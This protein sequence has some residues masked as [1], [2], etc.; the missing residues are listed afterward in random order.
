MVSRKKAK[1]ENPRLNFLIIVYGLI[2]VVFLAR[3]FTIQVLRHGMY[4]AQA[5]NQYWNLSVIPAKRGDIVSADDFVLAGTQTHYL[6]YIEPKK[7]EEP[8]KAAH[9][10][11]DLLTSLRLV[12]LTG[13]VEDDQDDDLEFDEAYFFQ[14]YYDRILENINSELYW[15]IIEHN[16]TPVEKE[17][18]EE[19]GI[20]GIGFEEEPVR[21]YPEGRLSSHV[22]GFVAFNEQG[23]K[24]GYF[25]I[26][27]AL[28]GDLKGKPGRVLEERDALG[29]PILIGSYK[30]AEPIKGRDI[31]LTIN[32]T[33]QY[34]VEK[35]L[36]E[37]VEE[38]DAKSGSVVV[39]DPFTGEI[40]AMAN[41]PSY[42]P[43]VF[44]Y[45]VED[46]ASHRKEMERKNLAISQ[47]YE[48]G[49]VMKAFTIS[50][51]VELGLVNPLTTFEDKG[52]V[53]YSDYVIDNWDGKHHGLQTVVQLLEKSNNIGAAWAGHL[54]GSE[55]LAY[56]LKEFGFGS[57]T[58]VELEGEDTGV[59]RDYNTWTDIDLATAA[60]GQGVS[61]TPLQ[62]LNGFNVIANNGFLLQP[63]MISQIVDEEK[64]ID[65]PTK[66]VKRVIS[67]DTANIMTDMLIRATE[68]G[69]AQFFV[70]KNYEIAGKTGTA[71]IPFEG[72]YDPER[73]NATFVGFLAG[74]KRFSMIIKLEEPRASIYASETAVPLWMDV[75]DELIKFFG[76]PPDHI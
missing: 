76:I 31:K 12:E 10:L 5:Q 19:L 29:N 42:R 48:P 66:Q 34:I 68:S 54:V 7:V 59:I 6:M 2:I 25:G 28:N 45:G 69:E 72:K 70:M 44:D 43:D 1:Q 71:Q 22:L 49:S 58:E 65:M 75:A 57:V 13:L 52:P 41:Y 33:V 15:V 11:A 16:L 8:Q 63:K 4:T 21:Y 55:N 14:D 60:F 67:K 46:G 32:R 38:F 51:A 53:R 9:E 47:T 37:G 20:A 18:I 64:V 30:K 39:M 3:L 50:S 24:Q 36:M 35:K 56:Y 27:G 61:A 23:E 26:E 73:T 40:L 17:T 62:V 74:S